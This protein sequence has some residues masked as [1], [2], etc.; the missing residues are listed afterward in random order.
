VRP[1]NLTVPQDIVFAYDI[2]IFREAVA[3]T[4]A[5]PVDWYIYH[6]R[7]RRGVRNGR[8]IGLVHAMVGAPAAAMNLEE[9][10]AYGAR[11]IYEV[12]LSGAIDTD[13]EPGQV[14]VLDGA[15][16][17]EGLSKHYFHSRSRFVAS[18]VLSRK[19]RT[20]LQDHG[21]EYSLGDAWTTDAPY[22]ET[23]AKVSLFRK[24]GARV[25]NMESSAVFA[26]AEYRGV[27]ACS[28]QIISD[29]VSEKEWSPAFHKQI[30]EKRRE[31]VLASVLDAIAG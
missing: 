26:I 31:E 28:V 16:S 25:V 13:L 1:S 17:D 12:G 24:K 11:R 20:S 9:L 14:V 5:I 29:V 22:R 21:P 7:M 15:L 2:A 3:K 19:I 23:T 27:E 10:I 8:E 6:D 18:R 30:V 4:A